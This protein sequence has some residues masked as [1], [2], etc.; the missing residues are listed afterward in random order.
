MMKQRIFALLALAAWAV[1]GHAAGTNQT[2]VVATKT[3]VA[4]N[5]PAWESSVAAGL[6][7]T[8]GNSDTLLATLAF[9]TH[10]KTPTNEFSFGLNGSY[11]ENN[12]V[13][14][15]ESLH[16]VGQYN[17]LFTK[18]FYGYFNLDGLHD[19]IADLKYRFTLSPGAG[20][21]FLNETN[22]T[23]AGGIG[24]SLIFQRLGEV[25]TT[26]VSLRLAERFEH[27]F[28]DNARVWQKAEFLPQVNIP[29]NYLIN[30]EIGV[31]SALTKTFSLQ[32]TLQDNFVNQPAPGRK[33]ND[34]K[35]ISSLVYK[36]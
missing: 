32:V 26:Y 22:T 23:L 27:K 36:F 16:E 30:A 6:S 5:K 11:G 10:T 17:H 1:S 7:L 20:Y 24:P 15:N 25:D 35:L 29:D 34:V 2:A 28:N 18:F 13:N 31:E 4:T 8:K 19:G 9:R 12:S 21:Y 14:N 3:L 33:D